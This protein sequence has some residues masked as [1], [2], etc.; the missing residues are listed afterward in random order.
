ML[1][2]IISVKEAV[3]LIKDSQTLAIGGFVG[4]SIPEE[5]LVSLKEKYLQEERPKNLNIFYCAGIGDGKERGLNHLAL[6]GLIGRL[7]CGHIGLAP[8]LGSL[9]S[10]NIFPA[11]TVPQGVTVHMLRAIAGRKPG[12]LTHVGLRTFADPRIEGCCA[13]E[14]AKQESIVDIVNLYGKDWLLYKAFTID[15]C[16]IK[17]TTGDTHGNLTLENEAVFAD[18]LSMAEA[19]KNSGGIVIA[20]VE[21]VSEYGTLRAQ[22]VKVHGHL[23]DYIVVGR[24]E[25]NCQS[26]LFDKFVPEWTGQIRRPLDSLKKINLNPR[27]ICGRRSILEIS[28]SMLVN[29]GIGFPEAVASVASE[30][31]VSSQFTLTIES[32][33]MGG[34]PASGVGIGA[35]Y[36]PDAIHEQG[37]I[38]DLYD[39]GGIDVA[40]LGA[41]QIDQKGNV[42]V[43]KFAGRVVGPGGFINITQNSKKVIFC[44]SFTANGME[45][46]IHDG[47]LSI[48]KEGLGKKFVKKVEQVTFS[49]E[50]SIETGQEVLYVTERAVFK[51]TKDGLE[52]I[53]IAPGVD[54]QKD[55][56]DQMEF[57]PIISNNLKDMDDRIFRQDRMNI[58]LPDKSLK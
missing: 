51:L 38:F 37:S 10:R 58:V 4:F 39:G 22:D 26:F 25:N 13:N 55:I 21:R 12:V 35:T 36:N 45:I 28:K 11:Y 29:L 47:K 40:C 16:F 53:E 52:L 23:V 43:S 48:T 42:N 54:L 56:L 6:E 19:T 46:K 27:K 34:V 9:V 8:K 15:V 3:D 32:G 24:D 2:K 49:A 18:Q 41:A 14:M 50:Y 7:Y 1:S 30:E 57:R 20:Q 33:V 5:L 44:G 31:G 17:A